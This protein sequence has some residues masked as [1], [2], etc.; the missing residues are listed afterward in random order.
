MKIKH[1]A[2]YG[3]VNAKKLEVKTNLDGTKT[4]KIVVSG[5][6]EWGLVREDKYDIFRWLLKRFAKDV[7]EDYR[8]IR[9]MKVDHDYSQ[10]I[11]TVTYTITYE[12]KEVTA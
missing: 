4:I 10:K 11:D 1:F 3:S 7:G 12:P 8:C 6:H 9:S 2:G 5:D